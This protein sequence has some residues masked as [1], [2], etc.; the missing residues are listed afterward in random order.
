MRVKP[1]RSQ[2]DVGS[3]QAAEIDRITEVLGHVEG[4][5]Q[6]LM[7]SPG[8]AVRAVE[9]GAHLRLESSLTPRDRQL[10]IAVV[11]RELDCGFIWNAHRPRA[12]KAGLTEAQL[13]AIW[14]DAIDLGLPADDAD[15]VAFVRALHRRNRAPDELFERLRHGHDDRWLVDITATMGQYLFMATVVNAFEVG[16]DLD[17]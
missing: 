12:V 15:V 2:D 8:T 14:S 9:L 11:A 7:H 4:P 3:E 6:V 16:K 13:D 10:V 5:F 17:V 1:L